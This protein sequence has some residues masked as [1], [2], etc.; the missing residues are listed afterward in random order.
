MTDGDGDGVYTA[1]VEL[2]TNKH[3]EYKFTMNNWSGQE[4]FDSTMHVHTKFLVHHTNRSLELGNL[5]KDVVFGN[6][7]IIHGKT[8]LT[9][10]RWGLKSYCR[11]N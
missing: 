4:Q 3:G 11:F 9:C 6:S 8:C 10:T 2:T 5:E 7:V 1:T